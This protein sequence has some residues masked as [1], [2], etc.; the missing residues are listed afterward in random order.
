MRSVVFLAAG[1]LMCGCA[2][3]DDDDVDFTMSSFVGGYVGSCE[4]TKDGDPEYSVI[5]RIE[6]EVG[7]GGDLEG[8]YNLIP[9]D[10]TQVVSLSGSVKEAGQFVGAEKAAL[11]ATWVS[12][13]GTMSLVNDVLDGEIVKRVGDPT[14]TYRLR[15]ALPRR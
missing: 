4:Q 10:R 9:D 3:D 15:F 7:R 5:G 14:A 2:D 11:S 13:S 8:R 12:C 6:Y 1:A